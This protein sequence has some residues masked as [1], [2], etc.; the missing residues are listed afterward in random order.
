ML[1]D[2]VRRKRSLFDFTLY[3][4]I[5]AE[6]EFGKPCISAFDLQLLNNLT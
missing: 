5:H 1:V 2:A 4:G 3:E 6:S